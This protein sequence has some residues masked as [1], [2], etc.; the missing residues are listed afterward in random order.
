MFR[1]V[2]LEAESIYRAK[3]GFYD[4]VDRESEKTPEEMVLNRQDQ[5]KKINSPKERKNFLQKIFCKG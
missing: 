5:A 2:A 4:A 3:K 1:L